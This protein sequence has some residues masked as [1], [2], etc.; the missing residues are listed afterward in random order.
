M[1]CLFLP[2]RL[3]R[4]FLSI[5]LKIHNTVSWYDLFLLTMLD[6]LWGSF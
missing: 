4:S 3:L 6:V 2:Q 5:G 1:V